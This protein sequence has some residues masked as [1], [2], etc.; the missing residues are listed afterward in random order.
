MTGEADLYYRDL[1]AHLDPDDPARGARAIDVAILRLLRARY[2]RRN[3]SRL[4]WLL[5]QVG[6]V[7][8]LVSIALPMLRWLDP[9]LPHTIVDDL[10]PFLPLWLGLAV[11]AVSLALV[12]TVTL[13]DP[14]GNPD[15]LPKPAP[16]IADWLAA[17]GK[18][19]GLR[20]WHEVA[21]SEAPG[22]PPRGLR[23]HLLAEG[24]RTPC[25]LRGADRA[26][27]GAGAQEG[28]VGRRPQSLC[29]PFRGIA[30]AAMRVAIARAGPRKRPWR[31]VRA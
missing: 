15:S 26:R 10:L 16:A 18:T 12:A 31:G 19:H 25:R 14:E 11:L 28:R 24:T 21:G 17:R 23:V 20:Y 4:M 2:A 22:P 9:Q 7:I 6:T 29:R 27:P 3:R 1:A 8:G 30:A 5:G 13:R